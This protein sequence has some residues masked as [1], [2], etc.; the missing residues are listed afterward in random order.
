MWIVESNT[1]LGFLEIISLKLS[2]RNFNFEMAI[3]QI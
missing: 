2:L 3:K 1:F